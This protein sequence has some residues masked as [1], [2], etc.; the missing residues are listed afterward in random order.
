MSPETAEVARVDINGYKLM[1][2]HNSFKRPS[3]VD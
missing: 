1:E 3:K 2:V